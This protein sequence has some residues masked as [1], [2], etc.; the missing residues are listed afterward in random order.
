[1]L[2]NSNNAQVQSHSQFASTKTW[3]Q[4]S[5]SF[6]STSQM[7][8]HMHTHTQVPIAKSHYVLMAV[9]HIQLRRKQ[10]MS[11]SDCF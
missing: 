5:F 9:K 2:Y 7:L 6:G 4:R 11:D 3:I 8:T 10:L 1:M